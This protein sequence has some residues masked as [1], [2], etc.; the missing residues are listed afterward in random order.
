ML[1]I[2]SPAKKLDLTTPSYQEHSLPRQLASSEQLITALRQLSSEGIAD[3]MQLSTK[4]S[5]LNYTRFAAFNTPFNLSN[6]KQAMLTFAGDVYRGIETSSYTSS[7]FEFAQDHLRILSGLYGLLRPLDLIQA[8]R[9][10]MGTKLALDNYSN[11]YKFWGDTISQ[12][13]QADLEQTNGAVIVNL[14]SSEYAKVI[15]PSKLT[16]PMVSITF[17]QP[18]H[19]KYKVIGIM[20][21]RARGLMVNFVIKHKITELAQLSTFNADGYQLQSDLSSDT[22]L[23]FYRR[24]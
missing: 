12:L 7:D 5:E 9:L 20:A 2:I 15:N 22:E 23:V 8:Y 13:L 18:S 19:G 6:A 24:A 1:L 11:L 21:K 4:L 14:A 16:S 17:K 3:L 10:E